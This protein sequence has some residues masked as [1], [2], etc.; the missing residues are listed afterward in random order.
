M[1]R[2]PEVAREAVEKEGA[3]RQTTRE[4]CSLAGHEASSPEG[5]HTG[6]AFVLQIDWIQG[7]A[8]GG[9]VGHLACPY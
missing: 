5:P 9:L 6:D 7:Q 8:C 4:S 3:D 1:E 2:A